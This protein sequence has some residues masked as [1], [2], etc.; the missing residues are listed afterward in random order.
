MEEQGENYLIEAMQQ[1]ANIKKLSMCLIDF[2]HTSDSKIISQFLF[3]NNSARHGSSIINHLADLKGKLSFLEISLSNQIFFAFIIFHILKFLLKYLHTQLTWN[4]NNKILR[5]LR[6]SY[7]TTK[8][9]KNFTWVSN[10]FCVFFLV[11][12]QI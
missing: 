8:I 9:C 2:F 12:I 5:I 11:W 7:Q 10:S 4:G 6:N 1:C 3:E